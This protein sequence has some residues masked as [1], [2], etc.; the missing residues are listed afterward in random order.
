MAKIKVHEKALAHLSRGLY[1]SPASALREL[2]SNAWDANATVVRL[3]TGAPHFTQLSVQDN[4]DGFTKEEF[5]RLMGGGI[6]NSEKRPREA[7]LKHARPLIGRLGIGM[8]GIAQICGGFVVTSKTKNGEGFRAT[9][10][11]YD[12][13]KEKLDR[14]D[15]A[16]VHDQVD[17]GFGREVDVGEYTV[18]KEFDPGSYQVGTTIATSDLHPTFVQSFRDS[19]TAV[20]SDWQAAIR[21]IGRVTTVQELGDYW[22]LLWELS[23]S[24]PIPYVNSKAIPQGLV[25]EENSRLESYKFRVVVD[26]IELRKPVSLRR[27]PGGYT[28]RRIPLETHRVFGRNLRFH[29][30][31][32]VQ[33]GRQLHPDEL[34]G[35]MIRIKEVGIGLYDGSLLDYRYNEGPRSRWITGEIFVDEG[36]EDALNIDRDSFNRFHPEFRVL[37]KRVH[38]ILRGDVFPSVYKNIDKRSSDRREERSRHRKVAVEQAVSAGGNA[39]VKVKLGG[40]HATAALHIDGTVRDRRGRIELHLPDPDQLDTKKAYQAL[41]SAILGLFDLSMREKRPD[42]RR[43]VFT[44]HLLSLLSRW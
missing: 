44:E 25:A 42:A 12:L 5:T 20:P 33:E 8:L 41:A 43:R 3:D 19:Y 29:G 2:A 37:Q 16:I 22:R 15:A 27:N 1:R 11:L 31:I 6:G 10:K 30:Y 40:K 23:A 35:V 34:R 7:V 28:C 18:E 26:G 38:E 13:I 24:C 4:G 39:N 17:D 9:V 36:V 21:K 32:V 14:D